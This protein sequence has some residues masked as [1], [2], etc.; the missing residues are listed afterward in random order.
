MKKLLLD[1]PL[2]RP[3]CGIPM[4]NGRL[5][6]LIWGGDK[7]CLTVNR[8]D[9]WDYRFGEKYLG[10]HYKK[11]ADAYEACDVSPVNSQFICRQK[12]EV[13][14]GW[15]SSTRLPCGRFEFS[16]RGAK[17]SNAALDYSTGN[18]M[19]YCDNGKHISF[20]LDLE[21]DLLIIKDLGKLINAAQFVS[22]WK[23]IGDLLAKVDFEHP[24]KIRSATLVGEIQSVPSDQS[25]AALCSTTEYGY[26]L[27]LQR[28]RDNEAALS[29]G[30]KILTDID[31][32]SVE[33]HC[34]AWWSN[35]WNQVPE[36]NIP[37]KFLK[38]FY[39]LALYKFACATHPSGVACGLQG[40]W[41]EE[42][43]KTPWSGD[44][45]FN[46]NIQ[47]IYTL[48]PATGNFEHLM[49]LF[50]MLESVPFQ[51]VMRDNAQNMFGI[52]DGLL[53]THAVDYRGMQCG[54][55]SAGT[56][57]DF[58][59]GGWMAQLYWLYY[60]YTLD[61]D[62]LR[63]R[64]LPFMRGVMRVF[65]ECLEESDGQLNIPLG[66]SAE[67][68]QIFKQDGG[69]A[70]CQTTG[71]N[72]SYQLACLHMLADI[73]LEAYK[74]TGEYPE[75]IWYDIKNRLPRYSLIKEGD[76]SRIAIW[77]GQDLD[78]CHRHH[79]H[80]ALIYPFDTLPY[81]TPDE[82][83]I[84]DNSIDRWVEKGMGQWSE[85]CYP[86]AAI[87]HARLGFKQTPE[88]LL[89]LWKEI[90]VNESMATVYLP[91]VQGLSA[92]RRA[93]M[94]KPLEANEI[95]Q[96]DGTMATAT[97]IIEMLVHHKG[98][99]VYL[100][101]GVPDKWADVSFE[102]VHLPGAFLISADR[103]RGKI[104]MVRVKSLKGGAFYI[105]TGKRR[106]RIYFKPKQ[107]LDLACLFTNNYVLKPMQ[108]T[109]VVPQSK[110]IRKAKKC[111]GVSV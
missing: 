30:I 34:K 23:Y 40:P 72:P 92:H 53:L 45:H 41:V 22:A 67:Y 50:D 102:N 93:D 5:G 83:E 105:W 85:W 70:T 3:H 108:T 2:L 75:K 99:T 42:Y 27:T 28:G 13:G 39:Q 110:Y 98:N 74:I 33:E 106:H 62:F 16:L 24:E 65:E 58:A 14:D 95:M 52:D 21:Q 31:V 10:P 76:R 38:G 80:L 49:P 60:K 32:S 64:A 15:W 20:H 91:R 100:F 47:Q 37:D 103:K 107:E 111:S 97:A 8:S 79:S 69:C 51:K 17:P 43:Q 104:E 63:K 90:F 11:L 78:V 25:L 68:K 44:Y 12:P 56:A 26:A 7:I 55:I 19:V 29:N 54:G 82:K 109:N 94:L 66:I 59:C 18:V 86:W 71:R 88:I 73:L 77:E 84:I 96:L 1:F 89:N 36:I 46:V 57:L 4:G 101:R 9:Y 48:A 6:I 87:I 61:E 35:Y 81:P